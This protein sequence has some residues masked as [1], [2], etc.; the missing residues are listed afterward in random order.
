MFFR[1]TLLLGIAA[2]LGACSG[3]SVEFGPGQAGSLSVPGS[4]SDSIPSGSSEETPSGP[5]SSTDGVVEINPDFG[6]TD[7]DIYIDNPIAGVEVVEIIRPLLPEQIS[8]QPGSSVNP[9]GVSC[10]KHQNQEVCIKNE[11]SQIIVDDGFER[12]EIAPQSENEFSWRAIINDNGNIIANGQNDVEF[13]SYDN[14][15][16]GESAP[17][18]DRSLYF[19]GRAG[20]SSVHSLY[21]VTK[22]FDLK[23]TNGFVY[24]SFDYLT[25][26]LEAGE[27][28]RLEVCNNTVNECG[29]GNQIQVSKLNS[30]QWQPIFESKGSE[31]RSG[32]NGF[33]HL[34]NDWTN[35]QL[36][37]R[38]DGFQRDNFVFRINAHMN[39]GFHNNNF[40]RGIED[41][42]GIDNFRAFTFVRK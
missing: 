10:F 29:V 25:F 35:K 38:L 8:G 6:F 42:V 12:D 22:S 37:V 13:R 14:S 24:F 23:D 11:D 31:F 2:F 7:D 33:N 32:L 19:T 9:D 18:G 41:G 36:A 20:G 1:L 28:L 21:L 26:G 5:T 4:G 40:R 27:F 3:E 16:L 17:G 30:N 39:E 34:E 15:V